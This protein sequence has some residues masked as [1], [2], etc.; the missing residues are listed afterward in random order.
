MSS[1]LGRRDLLGWGLAGAGVLGAMSLAGCGSGGSGGGSSGSGG[2]A[3]L[4]FMFWGSGDRVER[5]QGAIDLFHE[6]HPDI[7]VSPEYADIDAIKTKLSVAMSGGDLPDVF[8]VHG[9]LFAPMVA[10]GKLMELGPLFGDGIDAS[11]FTDSTLAA[12]GQVDGAQWAISHGL[13]SVGVFADLTVLEPLGIVPPS[14]P[15]AWTWDEYEE[16]SLQ[17]HDALG[18]DFWGTDEPTYAG[19]GNYF[20]AWARQRG[21]QLWTDDGDIG[22][23]EATF[24][25]WAEYWT[26]MRDAGAAVPVALALEQNPFFEGAP[27]IRGMAA[28]HMR[29]S[30]QMAELSTLT[31]HE[32][33]LMP[34]P[35]NGGE[36][37]RY[38]GLD[39]NTMA[40][41]ADTRNPEAAILFT[42]FM[43]NDPER[44]E[45]IGT[46]IGAPPTSA[47]REHIK[48][49]ISEPEAIFLD[50]IEFEATAELDPVPATPTTGAAFG[51][52][53]TRTMEELAYGQLTVDDATARVFGELRDALGAG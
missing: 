44:A 36:G 38:I 43:L 24:R 3:A 9:D 26:R 16:I 37:N 21:E 48:P 19:A 7:R 30:N 40:I 53:M 50:Y 18:P 11:G 4:R 5:F 34:S 15:E 45:I 39:P 25:E 8:W 27:M 52:G 22:F 10:E 13:Q 12:G 33:T 51:S 1:G 28:F 20:R 31:D 17:V 46:T 23:T 6:R 29:N 32:L 35:G 47:I 14:Y 2:S 42:D 41:S 49:T